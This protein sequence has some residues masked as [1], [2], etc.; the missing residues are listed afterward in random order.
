MAIEFNYVFP[1]QL[2]SPKH[3]SSQNRVSTFAITTCN[4]HVD[5]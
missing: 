3:G 1:L 2:F 5:T 4:L